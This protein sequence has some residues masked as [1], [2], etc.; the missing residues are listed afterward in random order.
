MERT[1]H[2]DNNDELK[3]PVTGGMTYCK[4]ILAQQNW[5]EKMQAQIEWTLQHK[6]GMFLLSLIVTVRS[7]GW[8][9]QERS[10][11]ANECLAT[12]QITNICLLQNCLL[13][14]SKNNYNYRHEQILCRNLS[15]CSSFCRRKN[16]HSYEQTIE[17]LL[18]FFFNRGFY[19][20]FHF[21]FCKNF[22]ITVWHLVD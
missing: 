8:I 18:F 16:V 1:D 15:I 22:I 5:K 4:L 6:H 7:V 9:R 12:S 21:A 20:S 14:W 10:R 2:E 17:F 11:W 3:V 13:R 19:F